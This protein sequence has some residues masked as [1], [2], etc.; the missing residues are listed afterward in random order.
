[1]F[2][3]VLFCHRDSLVIQFQAASCQAQ[4]TI[5]RHHAETQ[6]AYTKRGHLK[7]TGVNSEVGFDRSLSP[8]V[9]RHPTER[10]PVP[11]PV[12]PHSEI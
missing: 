11:A 3:S 2:R 8:S 6:R 12:V 10:L 7:G 4:R 1:M 9:V 5:C